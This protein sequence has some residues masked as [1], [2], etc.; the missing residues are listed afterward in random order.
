MI[1]V[2][3]PVYNRREL[4]GRAIDSVLAQS[5]ADFE[6]IIVDDGSDDGTAEHVEERYGDEPRVRLLKQATN[7]GV[8]AARNAGIESAVGDWLAFLDSDDEWRPEKLE[9]QEQAL[10]DFRSAR[11]PHRRD[12]DSQRSPGQSPQTPSEARRA[13]FSAGAPTVCHV[14]IIHPPAALRIRCGWILRR[15]HAGVRRLRPVP[16]TH[17]SVST[18]IF[19]TKSWS[20][21]TGDTLIS[22]PVR[23]SL[24]IDFASA[25]WIESFSNRRRTSALRSGTPPWR[26]CWKKARLVYKG[27]LRHENEHLAQSMGGFIQRWEQGSPG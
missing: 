24:W 26:C 18:C 19:W 7:C 5:W 14:A 17:L 11:L 23:T 8:S 25:P 21:S 9:R 1:S 6:L 13:H 10:I 15:E 16:E 4:I 2:I 20:S 12:L 3:I 22:C 27:A